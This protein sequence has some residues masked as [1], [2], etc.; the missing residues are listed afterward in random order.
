MHKILSTK[1]IHTK[2]YIIGGNANVWYTVI[3][4]RDNVK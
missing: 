2:M 1:Q 3:R 4:C